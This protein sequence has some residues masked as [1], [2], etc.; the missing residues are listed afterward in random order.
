[1][2]TKIIIASFL[3]PLD[4]PRSYE[5]IA[6][7]L[8]NSSK[9]NVHIV[10]PTSK[11]VPENDKINFHQLP[12]VKRT[13]WFRLFQPLNLWPIL[14]KVKPDMIIVNSHDLLWVT[15][16]YRIIFGCRL[17]YDVQENY[18]R[19]LRFQKNYPWLIKQLL[20][21]YV[22]FK[23]YATAWFIHY[24]FLAERCYKDELK[25]IGKKYVVLENKYYPILKD[26]KKEPQAKDKL[27]FIYTGTISREYGV[28]EAIDWFIRMHNVDER[29][30]MAIVG[31]CPNQKTYDGVLAQTQGHAAI[32]VNL[33]ILPVPHSDLLKSMLAADVLL[34]PYLNNRSTELCVPTKLFEALALQIPVIIAEN[35]LWSAIVADANAGISIDFTDE[36]LDYLQIIEQLANTAFYD[37]KGHIDPFWHSEE[38]KLLDAVDKLFN[39]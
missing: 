6:L 10:G 36:T 29:M 1:M 3:K 19:N 24:F 31:Y 4:D 26:P 39:Y 8:V 13:S 21:S 28:F 23:E 27:K 11:E 2:Q 30:Q 17:I 5:K 18:Y 32:S 22:R 9:Y 25:F 7:S 38:Q 34:L 15:V 20:A 35:P 16:L 14:I 33:S 12:P 37:K